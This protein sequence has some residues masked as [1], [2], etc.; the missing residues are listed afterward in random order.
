MLRRHEELRDK[1]EGKGMEELYE[2]LPVVHT[3]CVVEEISP[4]LFPQYILAVVRLKQCGLSIVMLF[5][6]QKCLT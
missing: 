5:P 2:D 3:T 6:S 1:K 4:S